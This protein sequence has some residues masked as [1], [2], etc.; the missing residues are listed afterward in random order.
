MHIYIDNSNI[1]IE[2]QRVAAVFNGQEKNIKDA[3]RN[4][5]MDKSFRINLGKLKY[6]AGGDDVKSVVIFGSRPPASDALW[7]VMRRLGMEPIIVDRNPYTNQE[8]KVDT[9]LV[10]RMV[11]DAYTKLDKTADRI[12]LVAGDADFVPT[13]QELRQDGFEVDVCFWAHAS[14]ELAAVASE[15]FD[16]TPHVEHLRLR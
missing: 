8:K 12:V 6:F 5:T 13:V 2:G 10:T 11:K 14:R 3:I 9:G 15:F 4:K 16:M 7:D 1:W